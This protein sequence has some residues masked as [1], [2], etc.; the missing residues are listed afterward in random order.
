MATVLPPLPSGRPRRLLAFLGDTT[1]PDDSTRARDLAAH[2]R[3]SGRWVVHEVVHGQ[4]RAIDLAQQVMDPALFFAAGDG[5]AAERELAALARQIWWR[6]LDAVAVFTA[7]AAWAML[8]A[9]AAGLPVLLDC[10]TDR[11]LQPPAGAS[12][13]AAEKLRAAWAAAS[14]VCYASHTARLAQATLLGHLPATVI[15]HWHAAELPPAQAACVFGAGEGVG[16]IR[17]LLD[18]AAAGTPVAA[19]RTPT[20]AEYFRREEVLWLSGNPDL[21]LAHARLDL[22]AN[23]TATA[24]RADL[25]ARR[26]RVEHAPAP[27]LA[28][29]QALLESL[30]ARG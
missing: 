16:T 17:P 2:L 23:P 13:A 27:L 21:A 7:D 10:G 25:A 8:P 29:W 30:I 6:H 9:R 26:L 3:A 5:A 12:A 18:A 14:A 11:P 19:P 20:M 1:A 28:R 15:P 22:A 24:R 4:P